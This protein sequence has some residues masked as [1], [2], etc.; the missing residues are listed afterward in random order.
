MNPFCGQFM[1]GFVNTSCCSFN[2]IHFHCCKIAQW[3]LRTLAMSNISNEYKTCGASCG[4]S[5][6]KRKYVCAHGM[7]QIR[8]K[9]IELQAK[10]L[11]YF[12][13][14]N[15]SNINQSEQFSVALFLYDMCAVMRWVLEWFDFGFRETWGE[16]VRLT[17]WLWAAAEKQGASPRSMPLH[18]CCV[19]VYV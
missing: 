14:N 8:T 1:Q 3:N 19:V 5:E 6:A 17:Q 18:G 10:L 16:S 7:S 13:G 12:L 15:K 2:C 4:V 11:D 9:Q